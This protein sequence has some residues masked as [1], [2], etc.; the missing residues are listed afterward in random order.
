MRLSQ[1]RKAFTLVELLV[2][3][4]IIGVMVG[5]LLPAVQAAREAARRMQCSNNLKQVSL[6]LHNYHSAY[7]KLPYSSSPQSGAVGTRQ[8]GASWLVRIFP[9]IEQNAAYDQLIFAGDF[10]MQ[11]GPIPAQ[12]FAVLNNLL[13]P[14]LE[15]PSSPLPKTQSHATNANGT[16]TLQMINYVGIAGSFWRGGSTN[17]VSTDPQAAIYGTAVHNG[18]LV[19]Q[20]P[21]SRAASFASSTDGTSNTMVASEQS[22]FFFD[23]AG[24]KIDRRSNGWRGG[25]WGN[26][27]G[28]NDWTQNVTTIRYP[29]GT[30][31]GT[32]N[33]NPYDVNVA[34]NSSHP[35][36]LNA[37][38]ADGSVRFLSESIDF[39]IM[40]ALA[41]R[42]DGTVLPEF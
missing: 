19:P 26:G 22:G 6:A 25:P 32:G 17:V 9:Y 36:G 8:R 33:S 13:V 15:C 39:A 29:I 10:T 1:A 4:A 37:T 31:G 40:T 12:N 7:N 3:I 18:M 34:L 16:V 42:A 35:G 23:A 21:N 28:A 14:G 24:N 41:D 5:L 2:V 38:L 27:A 11:D 20:A 30:F